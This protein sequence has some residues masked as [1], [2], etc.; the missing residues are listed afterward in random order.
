MTALSALVVA[1]SDAQAAS[2]IYSTMLERQFLSWRIWTTGVSRL[3]D[4]MLFALIAVILGL[5]IIVSMFARIMFK[6]QGLS[7]QAGW[8]VSL[9]IIVGA[10]V[11]YTM[12]RPYPRLDDMPAMLALAV[13]ASL[14][15]LFCARFFVGADDAPPERSRRE[16]EPEK[17]VDERRVKMAMR[18][19]ASAKRF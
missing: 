12:M 3:D 16:A 7:F 9:P 19:P 17:A 2:N 10:L 14:F 13:L 4:G 5:A 15:C 18:G 11:G 6:G 1:A 8:L